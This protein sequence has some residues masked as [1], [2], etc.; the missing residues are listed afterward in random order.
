VPY[1]DNIKFLTT[2]FIVISLVKGVSLEKSVEAG[3]NVA[4]H[5]IRRSGMTFPAEPDFKW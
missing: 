1:A 3:H 5:V 2:L 4:G